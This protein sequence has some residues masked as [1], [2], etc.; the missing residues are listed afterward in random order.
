M[1]PCALLTL[2]EREG[3]Y[4]AMKVSTSSSVSA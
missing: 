3:Y 1:V 2:P 4:Y